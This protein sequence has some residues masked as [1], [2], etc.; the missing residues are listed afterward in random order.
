MQQQD[1]WGL[2]S[3]VVL[4]CAMTLTGVAGVGLG[5]SWRFGTIQPSLLGLCFM[6][7]TGLI[8][9]V[10]FYNRTHDTPARERSAQAD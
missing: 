2:T 9:A 7:V 4:L 10:L 1:T 8:A 5:L 6:L 3:V